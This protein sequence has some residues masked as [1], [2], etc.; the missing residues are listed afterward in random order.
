[1]ASYPASRSYVRAAL[2]A[3]VR[4]G[5]VPDDMRFF[6]AAQTSSADYCRERVRSCAG[7]VAVVGFRYGSAVPGTTTSY[8]ELEFLEATDSGLPRFVFILD[9]QAPL[10]PSMVDTNRESVEAFRQRLQAAGVIVG[11]FANEAALELLVFQSLSDAVGARSQPP[12]APGLP[13]RDGYLRR[14]AERYRR[15]DL[16]ILTPTDQDEHVP[17]LLRSM[18]VP[19]SVRPDPPPVE[20]SKE[21]SRRL[22]EA[23]EVDKDDFPEVADPQRL[24]QAL[25]D[26]QQ[27]PARPVLEAVTDPLQRLVVLLG[28]PGSGK[29]TLARFVAVGLA[30][31][32]PP[33]GME[34]LTGA[35]PVLVEL[36]SYAEA[37]WRKGTF[38]DFL[39]HLHATEGLGLPKE[40]L[41]NYLTRDGRCVVIFDGLDELFDPAVRETV[42]RQI[43]AFAAR[44]PLVRVVVTS[45]VI[46]YRRAVLAT[47]GFAHFTIQD[48]DADQIRWFAT[49]WYELA[50]PGDPVEAARRR[51][52]LVEAVTASASIRELA[53]NPLLLTV[54]SIIGRRQELPRD[55]RAV[56]AHAVAVLVQHWDVNR[57]LADASVDMSYIDGEDKLELLRRV[58]RRMQ[59]SRTGLAGNHIAAPDLMAEFNAYLEERYRLTPDKSKPVAAAMLAQFRERNFILSRFGADVYGFV[60]RAF[61]EYL[62]AADI[63]HRFSDE[64]AFSPARLSRDIFGRHW[65]DPAW[66]EVLLLVA[67][68]VDE[69]FT[70]LII[71]HILTVNPLWFLHPAQPPRH[72]LLAARF[73]GDARK[74]GKLEKQGADLVDAVTSVLEVI[75]RDGWIEHGTHYIAA[76]EAIEQQVIPAFA[77]VGAKWP[78]RERYLDWFVRRGRLSTLH[79]TDPRWPAAA[80]AKVVAGLFPGEPAVAGVLRDQASFGLT[81]ALRWAAVQALVSGWTTDPATFTLLCERATTDPHHDV[82]QAAVAA[83]ASGWPDDPRTVPLLTDRAMTDANEYVRRGAIQALAA[84]WPDQKQTLALLR[85]Q[86][87]AD[88]HQNVRQAVLQAMAADWS[89]NPHIP[90]LLRDR[91]TSDVNEYVRRSAIQALVAGWPHQ[92]HTLPLLRR[93]AIADTHPNVRQAALAALA[94]GWRDHPGTLELLSACAVT[95]S[96][97]YVRQTVVHAIGAGWREDPGTLPLLLDRANADPHPSVRR[98][99]LHAAATGWRENPQ[100]LPLLRQRVGDADETVRWAALQALVAGWRDDP[101]IAGLLRSATADRHPDVR[102]AALQALAV[103][104]RDDVKTGETLREHAAT[105]PNETV[106]QAAVQ[107][108]VAGWRSSKTTLPLLRNRAL[109]DD[110]HLVR[111]TAVQALAFGWRDLDSTVAL[112]HESA[113]G[114]AHHNVRWTSAQAIAAGW[115]DAPETVALLHNRLVDDAHENVRWATLQT[116]VAGWRDE[117]S[118]VDAVR[119]RAVNDP[120]QHVRWAGLQALVTCW[121]EDAQTLPLLRTRGK[122]DPNDLVKR[123]IAQAL[124]AISRAAKV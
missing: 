119:D 85:K 25:A 113:T 36:R 71:D 10:P 7:Y 86:L 105:D 2:D 72:I 69:Q 83:L 123:S 1:M 104:W 115:P 106:R 61:L 88:P 49:R 99:A 8:T 81:P 80:S 103:G 4:A 120:H 45:R 98:A 97:E 52:R 118:T 60:H 47:A 111:R 6:P 94:S 42:A 124:A 50:C 92:K 95:D 9:A 114:D 18:F 33:A 91:A 109:Q 70:A 82:R 89:D 17:M 87:T 76:R 11:T 40:A 107:V 13:D 74:L 37:R 110:H 122:T 56:Y 57:F 116:L 84:R 32:N 75:A 43:A 21:L 44:Y 90:P 22:V 54:L 73:L 31:V 53:A 66:Q 48:L 65:D 26:Y 29:S 35:L 58:A 16:D 46:G 93:L 108:L 64:R 112:L 27:R 77:A 62:S 51:G 101:A 24:A 38:L 28:D 34:G 12:G 5:L 117:P 15:L 41:D 30:N 121:R 39:D 14:L 68:M 19:Q 78:G 79:T 102:R 59:D 100:T 63:V 23:G 96:N 55:R 67:G 3:V 20:L